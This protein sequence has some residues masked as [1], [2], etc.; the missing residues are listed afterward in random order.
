MKSK[1]LNKAGNFIMLSGKIDKDYTVPPG[2]KI[3]FAE[4]STFEGT[5]LNGGITFRNTTNVVKKFVLNTTGQI[6]LDLVST[7]LVNEERPEKLSALKIPLYSQSSA[8]GDD[9]ASELGL[10][11]E[12][13]TCPR[14]LAP[15][16]EKEL[17]KDIALSDIESPQP[18]EPASPITPTFHRQ[19]PPLHHQQ[20]VQEEE[21]AVPV[22]S[23]E[24]APEGQCGDCCIIL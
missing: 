10:P 17:W 23:G 12:I 8:L 6:Q 1:S 2:V 13:F 19:L 4:G 9:S 18:S 21:S 22:L 3:T 20:P 24:D 11:K 7:E 14:P 15:T 5:I 16:V